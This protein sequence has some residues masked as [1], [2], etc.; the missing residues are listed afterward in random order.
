MKPKP[1]LR[2]TPVLPLPIGASRMMPEGGVSDDD[3][4]VD[5]GE[6]GLAG[7]AIALTG[8]DDLAQAGCCSS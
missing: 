1:S 6:K 2:Q 3:G 5:F 7:V 8:T 4:Q